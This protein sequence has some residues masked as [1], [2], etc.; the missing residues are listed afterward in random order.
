[1]NLNFENTKETKIDYK[2]N[3]KYVKELMIIIIEK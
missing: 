2:Q 1:M 3:A